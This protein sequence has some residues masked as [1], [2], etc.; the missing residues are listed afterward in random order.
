MTKRFLMILVAG[1]LW[2]NVG[3]AA[4]FIEGWYRCVIY[5]QSYANTKTKAWDGPWESFAKCDHSKMY[6][7]SAYG[8][9]FCGCEK[10][11]F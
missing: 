7:N 3:F 1:L 5:T 9:R 11:T 6:L 4:V 8:K 10:K 2:G